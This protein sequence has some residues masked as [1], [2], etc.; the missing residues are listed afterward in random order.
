MPLRFW[1]SRWLTSS[2]LCSKA[3]LSFCSLNL[4]RQVAS[5]LPRSSF[6]SSPLEAVAEE[7]ALAAAPASLSPPDVGRLS[8]VYSLMPAAGG[9]FF[10]LCWR[11][12]SPSDWAPAVA[13]SSPASSA[14]PIQISS[15]RFITLT[16]VDRRGVPY[17]TS[18][19]MRPAQNRRPPVRGGLFQSIT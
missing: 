11:A 9:P 13:V 7:L 1:Y 6:F 19:S 10:A 3:I 18:S 15:F 14:P 12:Y 5:S 4:A 8:L 16:P 2:S 17:S